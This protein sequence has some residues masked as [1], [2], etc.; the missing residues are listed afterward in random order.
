VDVLYGPQLAE[1]V[2]LGKFDM[3]SLPKNVRHQLR[4]VGDS[5]ARIVSVVSI[6]PQGKY[7]AVFDESE[8][9][10]FGDSAQ[11]AL[12]GRFDS[13]KGDDVAKQVVEGRITRFEQLVPYKKDLNRTSGLPPE[14]TMALSAG[15]VFPLI[16]P[17]GHVGR[18]RTAP[19]YGNQGLYISIAEC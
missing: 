11:N 8:K 16:V 13:D 6:E 12:G 3:V 10:G 5:A 1:A 14:A 18:S 2:T 9:G 15:S 19:M 4:N 17:E 7:D